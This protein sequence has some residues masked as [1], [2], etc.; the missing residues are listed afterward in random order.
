VSARRRVAR[1]LAHASAGGLTTLALALAL[2]SGCGGPLDLGPDPDFLWWSDHE[3]GGL[4]DWLRGGAATG[5]MYAAGGGSV[6]VQAGLARSGHYALA[7]TA[8]ASGTTSAGQVTRRGQRG[9]AYYGAW[10]YVPA[11]ARPA[12]YWVFFS[13][14]GDDGTGAGDVALWDVKLAPIDAVGTLELQLLHHDTGDVAPLAHHTV[15]LGRWFQVQAFLR[16]AADAAG[17]LQI[18]LD[19]APVFDVGGPTTTA[20]APAIAWTAGTITDGLT[21]APTTLYVDDAFIAKR[22]IEADAPPFWRAAR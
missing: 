16:P 4:D 8:G 19:G 11:A 7:S 3:T 22:R 10:F 15:P 2:A 13:F 5:S 21:P 12:T 6:S 20:A 17:I 18:W 9:D 14:H 1:P